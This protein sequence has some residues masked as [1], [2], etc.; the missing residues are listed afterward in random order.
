MFDITPR[1]CSYEEFLEELSVLDIMD[2]TGTFTVRQD[3]YSFLQKVVKKPTDNRI[4]LYEVYT[5][6]LYKMLVEDA[7][8]SL[9]VWYTSYI[10][11]K[12]PIKEYLQLPTSSCLEGKIFNG[13]KY[14][15]CGRIS[16]Y[17]NAES[18]YNTKK[19]SD[20]DSQYTIGLMK[21]MYEKFHIRNSLACPAFYDYVVNMESYKPIWSV[22]MMG[23]NKP[24][25]FNPHTYYSILK[26][27][28]KGEVLFAPVM[29]WNS[30]QIGFYNSNFRHFI[31]TD[32]I[33]STVSN[34]DLIHKEYLNQ[35]TSL[36]DEPKTIDTYLCPSE[37]LG[38]SF[39]NKY[40]EKV[41]TVLFSPPYF[42]LEVYGDGEQ[43]ISSFP[44]YNNWLEGYW[45]QTLK[46]CKAVMKS[47]ARLGFVIS[48]YRGNP[49][50][51]NDMCDVAKKYFNL[52]ETY[53]VKWGSI[54][55]SRVPEKQK[56]GNLENLYIFNNI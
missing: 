19:Y 54:K 40:R 38:D 14:G 3:L 43:S 10:D 36:F 48:D 51:C 12:K 39:I 29:G 31:S 1:N 24:S 33:P 25:I 35:Y 46:L 2:K 7:E 15:K 47:N 17:L 11:L 37:Q 34:C 5:R 20:K 27:C 9:K 6:N 22:F 50:F 53:Q 55:M 52:D 41:D 30:Y 28:F 4:E 23:C 13:Q 56:N 26:E 44:L 21:V 42:D 18:F 49:N 32:V 16:K 8:N 45:E